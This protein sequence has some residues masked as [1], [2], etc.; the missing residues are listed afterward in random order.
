MTDRRLEIG[1]RA[2]DFVLVA[3]RGEDVAETSLQD[4]LE[5]HQGL[6]LTTY[7]LDFTG[8]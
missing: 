7:S 1:D 6:V 4:L 5:R 3:A 8:G 2:P